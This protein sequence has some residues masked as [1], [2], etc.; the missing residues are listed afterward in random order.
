VNW[1]NNN[2]IV[3]RPIDINRIGNNLWFQPTF[4]LFVQRRAAA[5][6]KGAI[7]TDWSVR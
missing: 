4:F 5:R 7:W 2:V 6:L 3:N 1:N